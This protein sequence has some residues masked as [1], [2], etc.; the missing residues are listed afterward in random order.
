MINKSN[1][2]D[3]YSYFAT[4][5]PEGLSQ[6]KQAMWKADPG[7]GSA[8][9]DRTNP[10]Q[11]TLF[12]LEPDLRALPGLLSG[13]FRDKGWI[14]IDAVEQFVLVETPFSEAMH[15]KAKTLR[16]MEKQALIETRGPRGRR[17]GSFP[18]GTEIRFL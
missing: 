10:D 12:Q 15:L 16:P 3:Y 6:M 1:R 7:G 11:I 14:S 18:P 8:F 17:K 2:T 4:N 13:H 9:S 5:H